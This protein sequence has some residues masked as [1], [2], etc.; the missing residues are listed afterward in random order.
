MTEPSSGKTV[1]SR[2]RQQTGLLSKTLHWGE[3]GEGEDQGLVQGHKVHSKDVTYR[4]EE[5]TGKMLGVD[6]LGLNIRSSLST[7]QEE[8]KQ[9]LHCQ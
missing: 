6:G 7:V 1:V 8:N 3:A 9:N 2:P 4:L 5:N